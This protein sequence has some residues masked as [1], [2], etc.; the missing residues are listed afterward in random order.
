M[1]LNKRI[2]KRVD[3]GS[4]LLYSFIFEEKNEIKQGELVLD[5]QIILKSNNTLVWML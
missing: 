1:F 3:C 2:P 4:Q 5:I